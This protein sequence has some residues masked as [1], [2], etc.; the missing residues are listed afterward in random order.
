MS[1][2]KKLLSTLILATCF[3]SILSQYAGFMLPSLFRK[4]LINH[5]CKKYNAKI[6]SLRSNSLDDFFNEKAFWRTF[7]ILEYQQK[8]DVRLMWF[9]GV[10]GGHAIPVFY[11]QENGKKALLIADSLGQANYSL[12]CIIDSEVF[13][14][15]NIPIFII[16]DR[17]QSDNY[18][19]FLD[20]LVWGK[21]IT[22]KLSEDGT[23]R[24]PNLLNFLCQNSEKIAFQGSNDRLFYVKKLPTTLL[25]TVQ[26]ISFLEK[27]LVQD[28]NEY[29]CYITSKGA[30]VSFNQFLNNHKGAFALDYLRSKGIVI[31]NH[32]YKYL[33]V[34]D[35]VFYGCNT[36]RNF[37]SQKEYIRRTDIFLTF[38][39]GFL[40]GEALNIIGI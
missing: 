40:F 29:D 27:Y 26:D 20:A 11:L 4:S 2:I 22:G 13:R 17:R 10:E 32:F 9:I 35:S 34:K 21:I 33:P 38:C 14:V 12:S 23:Y 5:Y 1:I 16:Q 39:F 25:A 8:D 6:E 28:H 7:K 15:L 18:S 24:I 30:R 3:N 19:C 37:L 31:S 36:V